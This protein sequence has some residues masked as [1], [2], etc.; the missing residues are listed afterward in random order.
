[1]IN[2]LSFVIVPIDPRRELLAGKRACGVL[3]EHFDSVIMAKVNTESRS[4]LQDAL[5]F[6]VDQVMPH[7]R[8]DDGQLG[9]HIRIVEERVRRGIG[10]LTDSS[11]RSGMHI[12]GDGFD[13]MTGLYVVRL[14]EPQRRVQSQD[15]RPDARIRCMETAIRLRRQAA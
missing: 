13:S 15:G 3:R 10:R 6:V 12:V 9:A 11:R 14:I 4:H 8:N 1:M 7:V 5:E 2:A